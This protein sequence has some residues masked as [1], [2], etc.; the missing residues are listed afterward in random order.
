MAACYGTS[1]KKGWLVVRRRAAPRSQAASH[2]LPFPLIHN[3]KGNAE[4]FLIRKSISLGDH[5]VKIILHFH[6]TRA[7]YFP[8]PPNKTK[9][10]HCSHSYRIL[11]L[12]CSSF[13]LN[14]LSLVKTYTLYTDS[15]KNG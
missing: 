7:I 8:F 5:Q 12:I 6:F 10:K 4:L 11:S 14:N 1:P 2:L 15:K 9:S 13:K 3:K